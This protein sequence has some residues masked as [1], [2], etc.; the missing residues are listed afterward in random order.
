MTALRISTVVQ[1]SGAGLRWRSR[2]LPR[3][4]E[5]SGAAAAGAEMVV[6]G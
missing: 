2:L 3:V 6:M 4:R 5:T 1:E